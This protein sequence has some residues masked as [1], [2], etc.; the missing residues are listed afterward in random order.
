MISK[1]PGFL[2]GLFIMMVLSLVMFTDTSDAKIKR[3]SSASRQFLKQNG[4]EKVP[5]GWQVD[6]V[7]PLCAGGP[8][9]PDNMQLITIETHKKKTRQDMKLC[10]GM[11]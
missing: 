6:H 10:K 7:I 5:H 2:P 9:T 1:R 4:F 11:K 8:D 3:S